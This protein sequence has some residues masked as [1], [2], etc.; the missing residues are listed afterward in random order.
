MPQ[1]RKERENMD[2]IIA[3]FAALALN[4]LGSIAAH[5]GLAVRATTVALEC[6]ASSPEIGDDAF[7]SL[8]LAGL[9]AVVGDDDDGCLLFRATEEGLRVVAYAQAECPWVLR[10]S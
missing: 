1:E 5:K 10:E 6:P 8:L 7:E 9:V 3:S 4:I 2:V